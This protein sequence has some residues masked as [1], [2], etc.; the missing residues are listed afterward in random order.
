M[1]HDLA[2]KWG[3]VMVRLAKE[4]GEYFKLNVPIGAEYKI[5]KNWADVH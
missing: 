3:K 5:G 4:V 1:D 2:E